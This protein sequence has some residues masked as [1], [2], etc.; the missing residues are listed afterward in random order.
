M[1]DCF[2]I[3]HASV[4]SF[5]L[6]RHRHLLFFGALDPR[7][8]LLLQ[9]LFGF[10]LLLLPQFLLHSLVFLV[11]LLPLFFLLRALLL[12]LPHLLFRLSPQLLGRF[13][14]LPL[15]V[16][17]TQPFFLL[18]ATLLFFLLFAKP[19][20]LFLL[21]LSALFD[22][23]QHPLFFF[24]LLFAGALP[25]LLHQAKLLLLFAPQPLLLLLFATQT[26]FSLL[27]DAEAFLFL[28]LGLTQS[29]L[30][31]HAEALRFEPFNFLLQPEAL[32][33]F[34]HP[35][36]RLFLA[37]DPF[38]F[39]SLRFLFLAPL[40]LLDLDFPA[41]F[42]SFFQLEAPLLLLLLLETNLFFFRFALD[43]LLLLLL[44]ADV[45]VHGLMQLALLQAESLFAPPGSDVVFSLAG[46][47]SFL[48]SH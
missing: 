38:R 14:T 46:S 22:L 15:L 34:Q 33:F 7:C 21:L 31:F 20:V 28:L 35:F 26:L 1:L 23:P 44:L 37:P 6:W 8:F 11:A 36:L 3:S 45:L 32:S 17:A 4:G 2:G 9:H 39:Q 41:Q 30:F 12:F 5:L 29:P 43:D 24:L 16:L 42:F 19:F 40:T 47:F 27:L 18:L 25:L 48:F 13:R 10:L